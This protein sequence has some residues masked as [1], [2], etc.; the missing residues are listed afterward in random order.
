[1]LAGRVGMWARANP[2]MAKR[3]PQGIGPELARH[4][5]DTVSITASGAVAALKSLAPT[6]NLLFGTDFPYGPVKPQLDALSAFN[7][8][9]SDTTL[10]AGL[11]AEKLLSS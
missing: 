3:Y 4:Y 7:L 1:M 8:C 11:N 6:S 2:A 9:P 10:I 5:Y